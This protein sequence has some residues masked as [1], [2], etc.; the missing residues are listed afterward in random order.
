MHTSSYLVRGSRRA[1]L[2]R[3]RE[4]PVAVVGYPPVRV[5]AGKEEA[6]VGIPLRRGYTHQLSGYRSSGLHAKRAND[7]RNTIDV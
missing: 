7:Y 2:G 3:R 5:A 1:F 6:R 4:N